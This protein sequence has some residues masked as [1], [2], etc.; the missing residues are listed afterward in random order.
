MGLACDPMSVVDEHGSV[1]G[2]EG[3]TV[4]DASIMP[5]IPRAP[6]QLTCML[7]GEKIAAAL[8]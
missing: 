8:R 5:T 4:A 3:L 7:I 6:T 1:H 2:C